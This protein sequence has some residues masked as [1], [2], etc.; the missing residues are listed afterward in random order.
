M[1]TTLELPDPL[2]REVKAFAANRGISLTGFFTE[3][4]QSFLRLPRDAHKMAAPP[5]DRSFAPIP[6]RFN[7]EIHTILEGEDISKA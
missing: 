3:A 1:R 2:F 7:L 6:A 4:T 5:V